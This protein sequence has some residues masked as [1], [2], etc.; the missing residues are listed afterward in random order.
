MADQ[1]FW[2]SRVHQ[3]GAGP[4]PI[5]R[6]RLRA[7]GLAEAIRV[8]ALDE[9][10]RTRA[11]SLGRRIHAEDGVAEAVEAFQEWHRLP[12]SKHP[13]SKRSRQWL[14]VG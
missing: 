5:P 7:D 6:S 8:A 12:Q 3:L 1:P 4:K 10:V 14:H 9:A 13:V 2:G 11:A